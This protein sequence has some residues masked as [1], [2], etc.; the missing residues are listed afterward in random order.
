MQNAQIELGSVHRVVSRYRSFPGSTDVLHPLIKLDVQRLCFRDLNEA[1]MSDPKFPFDILPPNKTTWSG[2][3]TAPYE[4][5][6][7]QYGYGSKVD[8][9]A[10]SK[11]SVTTF[12]GFNCSFQSTAKHGW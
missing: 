9:V 6:A 7:T 5:I 1:I 4:L 12:D 11:T 2:K 3:L 10:P 8:Q